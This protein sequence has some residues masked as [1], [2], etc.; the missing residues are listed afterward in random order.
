MSMVLDTLINYWF[1]HKADITP[2]GGTGYDDDN[3]PINNYGESSEIP[4]CRL[5]DLTE[6]EIN[7]LIESG[8]VNATKKILVPPTLNPAYM[9]KVSNIRT[10]GKDYNGVADILIDGNVYEVAKTEMRRSTVDE[11]R[12]VFLRRLQ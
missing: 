4:N 6:V 9:S 2:Y 5:Y 11:Y 12:Q 8:V 3:Q 7:S 10:N 1:V